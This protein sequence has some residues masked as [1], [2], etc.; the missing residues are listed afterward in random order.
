MYAPPPSSH[1]HAGLAAAA[2]RAPRNPLQTF[3]P[4]DR[5]SRAAHRLSHAAHR[6]SDRP[7]DRLSRT[8]RRLS[9]AALRPSRL[10][11]R[12]S[13][14]TLRPCAARR[15]SHAA[16]RPSHTACRLSALSLGPSRHCV[17]HSLVRVSRRSAPLP[18]TNRVID[19]DIADIAADVPI[20]LPMFRHHCRYRRY[21]DMPICRYADMPISLRQ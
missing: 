19:A 16:R 10:A 4:S 1:T 7:S 6:S 13:R 2:R 20:A 12:P 11:R 14:D 21:A 18:R 8:A 3:R 9:R 15:L 17:S 5:P